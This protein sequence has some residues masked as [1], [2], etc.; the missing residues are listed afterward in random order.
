MRIVCFLFMVLAGTSCERRNHFV[1]WKDSDHFCNGKTFSLLVESEEGVQAVQFMEHGSGYRAS[2]KSDRWLVHWKVDDLKDGQTNY[3]SSVIYLAWMPF[4]AIYASS[5][6]TVVKKTPR[7]GRFREFDAEFHR[8]ENHLAV[9]TDDLKYLIAVPHNGGESPQGFNHYKAHCYDFASDD[10]TTKAIRFGANYTAISAIENVN[11]ELLFIAYSDSE[12][13]AILNGESKVL[14]ELQSGG[15]RFFNFGSN[16]HWDYRNQ[17][18]FVSDSKI[19]LDQARR[20]VVVI[21]YDYQLGQTKRFVLNAGEMK[22]PKS[23]P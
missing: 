12:R 17:R 6:L 13:L 14:V 15:M 8:A 20:E 1:F 5:N 2:S 11:G 23:R 18:T 3:P 10:F 9:L 16:F 4:P 22:I 21:E 7:T 19:D